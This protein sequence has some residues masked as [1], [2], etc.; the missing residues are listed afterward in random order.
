MQGE[1]RGRGSCGGGAGLWLCSRWG[2]QPTSAPRGL[3]SGPWKSLLPCRSPHRGL[4]D[5]A[6]AWGW[7]WERGCLRPSVGF[8]AEGDPSSPQH[9]QQMLAVCLLWGQ[10]PCEAHHA[11]AITHQDTEAQRGWEWSPGHTARSRDPKRDLWGGGSGRRIL[12]Q[13]LPSDWSRLPLLPSCVSARILPG[14]GSSLHLKQPVALLDGS[15]KGL[16][17]G[18]RE[19]GPGSGDFLL[20]GPVTSFPSRHKGEV[21]PWVSGRTGLGRI[22]PGPGW[23]RGLSVDQPGEGSPRL[24]ARG[25]P[26]ALWAGGM[27]TLETSTGFP[28]GAQDTPC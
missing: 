17:A 6:E 27:K 13:S 21:T 9:L 7:R 11:P 19:E 24:G 23:F 28:E 5:Q 20:S 12:S 4:C 25:C 2:S 22:C 1:G 16:W 8:W 10:T 3:S 18:R 26:A 14:T 15:Q